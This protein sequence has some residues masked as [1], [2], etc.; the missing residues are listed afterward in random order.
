MKY[1]YNYITTNIITGKQ[2]V[3]MH[4]SNKPNDG[5]LGSGAIFKKAIK[6]YGRNNFK[7]EIICY[8]ETIEEAYKNESLFISKY[9]TVVPFGYNLCPTGGLLMPGCFTDKMRES[10]IKR[11]KTRIV[12]ES[13]REKMRNKIV[14]EETKKKISIA[15]TGRRHTNEFKIKLGDRKRG[16]KMS[17]ET[18][19]KMS[20]S[21][22]GRI[23]WN[24]GKKGCYSQEQCN[25]ISLHNKGRVAWNK[26]IPRTDEE[27]QKIS[28][29]HIGLKMPLHML[30]A[31][32]G[33][34]ATEA[35]RL[36][37]SQSLIGNKRAVK[38]T[39]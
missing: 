8:C 31:Q 5:Y 1:I 28:K 17:K 12:S 36:K 9:N 38:K 34:V 35:T 6:G 27:K 7:K 24:K 32:T 21:M 18:C 15:S 33:R 29:S 13:T 16:V 26:G 2:Y 10:L 37:I 11:N 19:E 3:G 30:L 25:N 4:S 20:N 22:K 39:A 23:P 14:S